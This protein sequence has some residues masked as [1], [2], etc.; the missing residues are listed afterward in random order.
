MAPKTTATLKVT[1]E[2]APAIEQVRKGRRVTVTTAAGVPVAALVSLKDL[3]KIER[4]IEELEDRRDL[5]E[6]R[7]R[8]KDTRDRTIPYQQAR[9]K[10]GLE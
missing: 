9:R 6:A 8:L 3:R 1:D 4:A 2:I 10:L 7:K 5:A